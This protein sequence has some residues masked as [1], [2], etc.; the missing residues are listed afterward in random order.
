M[1][2]WKEATR[3]SNQMLGEGI[4]PDVVTFTI[5]IDCLCKERKLGEARNI[6]S[7][8]IKHRR[9]PKLLTYNSLINGLYLVGQVDDAEKLF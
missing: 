4:S 9:E 7:L 2:L 1:G 5:L 3:I 6:F 8:M